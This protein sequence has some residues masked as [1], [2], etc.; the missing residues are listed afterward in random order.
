VLDVRTELHRACG[1]SHD[2]L[3]AQYT[4]EISGA[5]GLGDRYDLAAK[6]VDAAYR[7]SQCVDAALN[8]LP[9]RRMPAARA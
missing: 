7:I 6:L 2:V 1:R 5:L 3:S 4:D 9:Y 8:N